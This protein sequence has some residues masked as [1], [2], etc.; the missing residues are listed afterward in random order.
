MASL[1]YNTV[2]TSGADEE[3]LRTALLSAFSGAPGA[4]AQL[5]LQPTAVFE[6]TEVRSID[7]R[8]LHL[9]SPLIPSHS[10]SLSFFAIAPSI[11]RW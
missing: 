1:T 11:K 4:P 5:T 10:L 8:H 6:L 2:P 3:S 7:R 9:P